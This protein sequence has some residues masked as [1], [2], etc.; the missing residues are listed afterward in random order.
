MQSAYLQPVRDLRQVCDSWFLVNKFP[1][2]QIS[3]LGS[4]ETHSEISSKHSLVALEKGKG[5]RLAT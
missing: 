3:K 5:R 4:V 1:F 2:V